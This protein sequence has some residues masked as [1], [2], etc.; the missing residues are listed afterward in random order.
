M[1]ARVGATLALFRIS[2]MVSIEL[3]SWRRQP[4][5]V[6]RVR[7]FDFSFLYPHCGHLLF[8]VSSHRDN[9]ELHPHH[10]DTCFVMNVRKGVGYS[11]IAL[12]YPDHHMESKWD[13]E[14]I[15]FLWKNLLAVDW[16]QN[17]SSSNHKG[18]IAFLPPRVIH[19]CSF[20]KK[21]SLYW[22]VQWPAFR[23]FFASLS[24]LM[25]M[26]SFR[27][28]SCHFFLLSACD[29]TYLY[30]TWNVW[31]ETRF[32]KVQRRSAWGWLEGRGRIELFP[33]ITTSLLSQSTTTGKIAPWYEAAAAW[34]M[35]YVITPTSISPR[36]DPADVDIFAHVHLH[37]TFAMVQYIIVAAEEMIGKIL[38]IYDPSWVIMNY[39]ASIPSSIHEPSP[40]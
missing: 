6:H 36:Y 8:N 39:C 33:W 40:S 10:P 12:L 35:S 13:D 16:P 7:C 22:P 9:L 34:S 21:L 32:L 3:C 11:D 23:A 25:F 37:W 29:A 4:G 18:P 28:L 31:E 30:W 1:S 27:E 19:I 17:S 26:P 20:G 38:F 5:S 2:I 24:T 14:T 15:P